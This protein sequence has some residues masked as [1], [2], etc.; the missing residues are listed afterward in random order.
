MSRGC[1]PADDTTSVHH[2]YKSRKMALWLELIPKIHR[3]DPS[4]NPLLHLLHDFRNRST[5]EDRGTRQVDPF[6][7]ADQSTQPPPTPSAFDHLETSHFTDAYSP[8]YSKL[9]NLPR[10]V[11]S[12]RS[13]KNRTTQPPISSYPQQRTSERMAHTI[14]SPSS[15]SAASLNP[16]GQGPA[17]GTD[18][19][20]LKVT[21]AIGLGLL[22]LN[23]TVF[24]ATFYQWRHLDRTSGLCTAGFVDKSSLDAASNHRSSLRYDAVSASYLSGTGKDGGPTPPYDGTPVRARF[25]CEDTALDKEM[26]TTNH[27]LSSV[28]FRTEDSRIENHVTCPSTEV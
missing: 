1:C 27:D 25:G 2:H 15:D 23:L 21:L 4:P 19:G 28:E 20:T 11:T 3:P 14:F 9:P 18:Y 22:L 8:T 16:E 7:L 10:R 5:F 12:P 17:E 13:P 26:I 24:G 6:D